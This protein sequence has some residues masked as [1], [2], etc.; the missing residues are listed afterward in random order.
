LNLSLFIS[1]NKFTVPFAT[2]GGLIMDAYNIR[3]DQIAG[4]PGWATCTDLYEIKAMTED[5][6]SRLPDQL[7]L[8]L[9]TLLAD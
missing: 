1:G 4:L 7:R 8:V 2:L 5:Q 9:Q 3:A 6:E